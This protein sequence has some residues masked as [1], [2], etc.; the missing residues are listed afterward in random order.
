M[1]IW[2][3]RLDLNINSFNFGNNESRKKNQSKFA[4]WILNSHREN[5]NSGKNDSYCS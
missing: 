4:K 5:N 2:V 1:A 3:H